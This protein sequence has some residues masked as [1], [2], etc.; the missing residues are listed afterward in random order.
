MLEGMTA[1][2]FMAAHSK[3]A[4][5][6]LMVGGIHYR[7]IG[8]WLKAATTLDVLSGGRAWFGIGAAWNEQESRALGFPMPP[9]RQRF[10]MLEESSRSCT[11]AGGTS[12]AASPPS[13]VATTRLG[14]C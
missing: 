4:R 14:T 13:R 12:W 2:G 1:L 8:L 11:S 7:Q 6:G 9:L 3:R 5:L 10:E